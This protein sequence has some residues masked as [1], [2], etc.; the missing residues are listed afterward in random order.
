MLPWLQRKERDSAYLSR[1]LLLVRAVRSPCRA[2]RKYMQYAG[3]NRKIFVMKKKTRMKHTT[4][5]LTH[6]IRSGG[7]VHMFLA[8]TADD[9]YEEGELIEYKERSRK[10]AKE[11]I[12]RLKNPV[13][14]WLDMRN[15]QKGNEIH[16][17]EGF[18]GG[19]FKEDGEWF[20]EIGYDYCR[21]SRVINCQTLESYDGY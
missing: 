4:K 11:D 16:L 3:E 6:T 7:I 9:P 18:W 1:L 21:N 12:L 19:Y 10:E 13:C 20:F 5:G 14:Y 2:A 15:I 17:P 8:Y